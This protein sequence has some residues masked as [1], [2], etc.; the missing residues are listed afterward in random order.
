MATSC[1]INPTFPPVF[2]YAWC[3]AWGD[4]E[5]GIWLEFSLNDI[6]QRLRWINPGKF[7]MGSPESE[8]ERYDDERPHEV[9]ISTGFWL[10]ETACTQELWQAVMDENPSQFKGATRPVEQVSWEDCQQFLKKINSMIPELE[11]ALPSE[12]QWEYAC[13]AGTTTP[14]SFGQNITSEQVNYNGNNPYSGGKKG[15]FRKQTVDV[16]SLPPNPWGLYEMHGN[17]WEWCADWFDEY[18]TGSAIDPVGPVAGSYR[19]LRGGSWIFNG[20]D[21]RS[22]NR[23]MYGPG[24]RSYNVGFRFS[25]GHK[26]PKKPASKQK[27]EQG[28]TDGVERSR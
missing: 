21:C 1:A 7:L 24:D 5:F 18:P 19:V 10:A 28:R 4:D 12:A 8:K 11:L 9:T 23:L 15:K 26:E 6:P 27:L 25:R 14:F 20:G 2:P 22:A 17:V 13:R 3:S 16:K